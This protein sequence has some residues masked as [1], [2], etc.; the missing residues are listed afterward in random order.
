MWQI[1]WNGIAK[2]NDLVVNNPTPFLYE[3]P[4]RHAEWTK[5]EKSNPGRPEDRNTFSPSSEYGWEY[6][7]MV[8]YYRL[9]QHQPHLVYIIH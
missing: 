8:N 2:A 7:R 6:R 1:N 5:S 4:E 9:R 3:L